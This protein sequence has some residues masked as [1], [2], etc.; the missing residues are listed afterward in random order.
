MSLAPRETTWTP[1]TFRVP[2]SKTILKSPCFVRVYCARVTFGS[3]CLTT[4]TS[5][6]PSRASCS[7]RPMAPSSGSVKIAV[8]IAV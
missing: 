4:S 2:A 1:S 8:G 7:V 6:P 3:G 5:C